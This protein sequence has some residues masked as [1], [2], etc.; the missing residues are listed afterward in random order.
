LGLPFVLSPVK[1]L[2]EQLNQNLTFHVLQSNEGLTEF[3]LN[4][5]VWNS[6]LLNL[7]N[8]SE[9]ASGDPFGSGGCMVHPHSFCSQCQPGSS[10]AQDALPLRLSTD[11]QRLASLS[12]I[13]ED[14]YMCHHCIMSALKSLQQN[15]ETNG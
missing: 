6:A 1:N 12:D 3:W 13:R 10:T 8:Q 7:L 9:T 5:I 15:G 2:S 4:K 11:G 14:E